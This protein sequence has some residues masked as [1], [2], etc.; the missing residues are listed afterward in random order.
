M[1]FLQALTF[2]T[3]LA[4]GALLL[5]PVIWWLLR[6]TPPRP[7]T[8]RFPAIRLLLGLRNREEKPDKTPWW[9]LLLRLALAALVIIGV[10]QPLYSPGR[11]G[12][13]TNTPVLL[14]VDAL[15]GGFNRAHPDM[16]ADAAN[17][18]AVAR[19]FAAKGRPRFNPLICHYPN[20]TAAF[21]HV[22][23]NAAARALAERSWPG[24]LSCL[25][26]QSSPLNSLRFQSIGVHRHSCTVRPA[27]LFPPAVVCR[28]YAAA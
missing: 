21:A 10:S 26:F 5:L 18:D 19:I 2:T 27:C 8:V 15:T 23:A 14:V 7:E 24:P 6:F 1:S 13:L 12:T 11:I 28:S 22:A 20:A 17:P 3:P 16:V 4:L 25:R 9:L